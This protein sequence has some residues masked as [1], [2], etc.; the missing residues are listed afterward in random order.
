MTCYRHQVHQRSC[1]SP[2]S[3]SAFRA[4]QHFDCG[5]LQDQTAVRSWSGSSSRS[6]AFRH[7]TRP[8]D[9]VRLPD[10]VFSWRIYRPEYTVMDDTTA[11]STL[12]IRIWWAV[13]LT[14]SICR[15]TTPVYRV[16]TAVLLR[17]VKILVT[18]HQSN[19]QIRA[20]MNRISK[21]IAV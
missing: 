7:G 14:P 6:T 2:V 16:S 15:S 4:F 17:N 18:E 21:Q 13:A 5:V 9:I 10:T 11:R 20:I 8:V 3:V 12:A 19:V 1:T